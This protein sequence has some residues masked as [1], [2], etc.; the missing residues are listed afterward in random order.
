MKANLTEEK[1]IT[2]V[3]AQ[4]SSEELHGLEVRLEALR[5]FLSKGVS[6]S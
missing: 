2:S 6:R 1:A 3:Q 5:K 4:K